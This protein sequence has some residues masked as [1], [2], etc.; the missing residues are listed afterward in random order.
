MQSESDEMIG[1]TQSYIVQRQLG[2]SAGML[3][4]HKTL[5]QDAQVEKLFWN[6]Q[7]KC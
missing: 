7:T 4:A 1:V 6:Y 5:T 2:I 3:S